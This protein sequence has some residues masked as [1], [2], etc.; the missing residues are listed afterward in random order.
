MKHLNDLVPDDNAM[1]IDWLVFLV[2]AMAGT[3][4]IPHVQG[5]IESDGPYCRVGMSAQDFFVYC[6]MFNFNKSNEMN[7][8]NY[9]ERFV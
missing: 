8:W 5:H 7:R 6:L 2:E 4:I 9:W 1:L 3:P